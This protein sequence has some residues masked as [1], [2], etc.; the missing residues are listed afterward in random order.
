MGDIDTQLL[1][2]YILMDCVIPFKNDKINNNNN[3]KLYMYMVLLSPHKRVY[4][5]TTILVLIVIYKNL[6]YTDCI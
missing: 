2:G 5:S 6:L 1:L 3:Y 4:T